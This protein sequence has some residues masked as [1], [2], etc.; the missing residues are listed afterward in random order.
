V[1]LGLVTAAPVLAEVWSLQI[2]STTGGSVTTPGEGFFCC[3]NLTGEVVDLVASPDAGYLFVNWSGDVGTIADVYA[4]TTT[5]SMYDSYSITANFVRLYDLTVSSTAGGSVTTPG[6]GSFV[7]G[8]GTVVN[9]VATPDAGYQFD[10]WSG[11]VGTIANVNAASTTITM[12]GDYSIMARF[13]SS[14][15]LECLVSPNPTEVGQET[16]FMAAASGGVPPYSWSWTINSTEVAT[17]QNTTHIF[18]TAGN[19]SVGVTVTDSL[20]N[21][22]YAWYFVTVNPALPTGRRQRAHSVM[23]MSHRLP[24]PCRLK[25]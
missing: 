9:L 6:E 21:S 3:W 24:S 16:Y 8:E 11:D 20:Y 7:Y 15:Y 23:R 19:Y 17:T 4:A 13:G 12:N 22:V 1:S 10:Y 18:A 14:L 5:I 25:R 2:S